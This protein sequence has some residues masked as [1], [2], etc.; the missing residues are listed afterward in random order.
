ME[1]QVAPARQACKAAIIQGAGSL[2]MPVRSLIIDNVRKGF[3]S[4]Q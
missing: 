3:Y 4:L 1:F 2:R